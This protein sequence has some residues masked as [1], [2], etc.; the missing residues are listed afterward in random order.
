MFNELGFVTNRMFAIFCADTIPLLMLP[1]NLVQSIYGP[2]AEPLRV[3]E[4]VRGHISQILRNPAPYW[5][6]VLDTRKYLAEHHSFQRRFQQ[7]LGIL[8]GKA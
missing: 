8:E 1:R 7:L 5:K 4:D 3:E 2:S 6:A